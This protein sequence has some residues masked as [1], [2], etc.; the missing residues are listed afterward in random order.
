[1]KTITII[2]QAFV[3]KNQPHINSNLFTAF[4]GGL[5]LLSVPSA[6]ATPISNLNFADQNLKEC[7]EEK[8]DDKDWV[9]SS[10]VT[11]LNCNNM[12]IVDASGIEA[13]TNLKNLRLRDNQITTLDVSTLTQLQILNVKN[14]QLIGITLPNAPNLVRL[15]LQNNQLSVLNVTGLTGLQDLRV[16]N[17]LLTSLNV[18]NLS[19]LVTLRLQENQLTS[20][21]VSGLANLVDLRVRDNQLTSLNVSGLTNLIELRAKNNQLTTFNAND[22]IQ[23]EK[24]N[25]RN[26]QLTDVSSLFG[27]TQLQTLNLK[28]NSQLSCTQLDA[29][30]A[31]LPATTIK[32]PNPCNTGIDTDG[33]GIPNDVDT[34]DDNDGVLD[35]NDAF[36][37]DP[38]ESVDTDNDG[39]GNNADTDDDND[40]VLDVNDAF[41]LDP[42]ESVDTDN[43][44]I[45]NNAD[46]DDDNDGVL[47]VNDAFPLD[48]T[49]SS[50]L[51]GDGIG[52]NSDPDRDGDGFDNDIE[53]QVGT[54]PNDA[55]SVPPD[56]DG[57]GIPDSIDPD[58]DGNGIPDNE[59]FTETSSINTYNALGLIASID[60]P[61]TDV[62]DITTFDY[63]AQGNLI[64]TTNALGQETNITSHDAHGRPLTIVDANNTTTTLTYDAR[65]RLLTRTV[66]SQTTTFEYN[67]VGNIT[68]TTLPNGS[69]LI[70]EYDAAQRLTAVEDNLG[71]RIEYTLDTLGNRTQ[72]DVKDPLG[73]LTRTMSRTYNSLNRLIQTTGG[74]GQAT[75]FAY[76]ANGN[77]TNII[78]DPTSLDPTGLNQETIQAFDALN[79]LSTTTDANNG[80]T[81]YGYDA[82]DNL[83]SVTDAEGLTTTY[84]YN[85]F[86]NLISQTSPDTGLTTFGYDTAGNRTRQTDARRIT[87]YYSYDALNRLTSIDYAYNAQD[88]TYTYDTCTNGVGRLCQMTD[89]SGITTYAYDAR[90]NLVSQTATIDS[91]AYT[92]SYVYN[93]ADQLTQMTYPSGRTVDYTRNT[94]GQVASVTTTQGTTDTISS[95]MTYQPFGPMSGMIYGNNL[96]QTKTYD[97]DYRLTSLMTVNGSTHQDLAYTLDDANNITDITNALDATRT[98]SLLYDEL[99]RLTDATSHYGDI[100]YTYDNIGN[101]LSETIDTV[102]ETYTYDVN[103]HHLTQT[104]NGGTTNYTYDANGNTTSNTAF[105]FTYGDNNRLK[106]SGIGASP[107]ATYTYNGRGERV[108]KDG[109]TITYYHYDQGGQLIA[110]T[111]A[112]GVTQV[113]YIYID[114]QPVSIV[115]GGTLNFIHNDHLGTPQQISDATQAIVWQADYSPFGD[116]TITTSLITNNLRFPGQYYDEET[117]LHYNYYRYYDPKLGR[118]VTSDPIGLFAGTNTY[119][120]VVNNPI[121]F[122]DPIGLDS[123]SIGFGGSFHYGPGGV[124][125][126][127]SIGID[128]NGKVCLQFTK[129]GQVGFGLQG[130]LGASISASDGDFCEGDSSTEG[131]FGDG[132]YGFGGGA[133]TS[134]DESG[135][136]SVNAARGVVGFGAAAGKQFCTTRTICLN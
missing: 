84:T 26:N 94:L 98:Q 1:M 70:N 44:G 34:D 111:D 134:S 83:I 38:T 58:A 124:N 92:T 72:E 37:L 31:A 122:I 40:G 48:P 57:D 53:T 102:A 68:K 119:T 66:D 60:G 129:C 54:D 14:N 131:G 24:L 106:T 118:Y 50:D 86:D 64:K 113:E 55:G 7:V 126:S 30:E 5:L 36:P 130:G 35:V 49:E 47:D 80:I 32:R 51:D 4:L 103:S 12:D 117:G 97:L 20:L 19:N 3:M 22:L 87:T 45:G 42:T 135:G 81:T 128:G 56:Q 25:V 46:T 116:A 61:R 136:T 6:G 90:G 74:E 121:N 62:N 78:V 93:G 110:E 127:S 108:K 91:I 13:L 95:T 2:C 10:E 23:V 75:T 104:V 52:D 59:E 11:S 120:Y 63:D 21:N 85:A 18:S 132:A 114:G 41:P 115:T 76:D 82:R 71:N 133:S 8:A 65:G 79:R 73:T 96:V 17:N 69:F 125:A 107:I 29:L 67:G 101:R 16:R 89:E 15:R 9:D 43:D 33:D 88:V 109:L 100:D 39:I 123:V 105:D 77:Q 28:D 99:N 112:A 27:L